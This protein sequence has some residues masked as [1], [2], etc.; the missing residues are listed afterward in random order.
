MLIKRMDGVTRKREGGS[1]ADHEEET[2]KDGKL[3][4]HGNQSSQRI[5]SILPPEFHC[6]FLHLSRITLVL[7][8]DLVEF[9]LNFLHLLLAFEGMLCWEEEK[10]LHKKREDDDGNT[11]TS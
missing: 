8:L 2:D 5:H 11:E 4:N 6:F 1:V 7:L 10:N 3:N 9:W